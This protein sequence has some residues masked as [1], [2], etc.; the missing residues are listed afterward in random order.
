MKV[1]DVMIRDFPEVDKNET[2]YHAYKIMEKHG[3]DKLVVRE[4]TRV[5]ERVV[6]RLAGVLTSRDIVLK[7]ATERVRLTTPSHLHVSSFMTP[8]PIITVSPGDDLYDA[9]RLME[10]KG[11]GILPV[12]QGTEVEGIVLRKHILEQLSGDDTEVRHIMQVHPLVARTYDKV[13][14]ARHDMMEHDISF[15][16]VLDEEGELVGYIT[17]KEIAYAIFKFQDIVPAKHRKERIHHLLVEDIMRF[18]PPRLRITDTV[19]TAL[20]LIMSKDSRGAVVLDEIGDVAGV[21]TE[22]I[23]LKHYLEKHG[24]E[25]A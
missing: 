23:L 6:K 9:A 16:P 11:I 5:D 13:L 14:K 3:L 12:L 1:V 8:M 20:E 21:V 25:K 24:G 19:S 22:H 7:L 10:E 2:L 4:K 17:I 18:R 15:L